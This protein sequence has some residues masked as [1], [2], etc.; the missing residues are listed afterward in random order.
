MPRCLRSTLAVTI[1]LVAFASSLTAQASSTLPRGYDQKEGESYHWSGW[2]ATSSYVPARTLYLYDAAAFPW[3]S[4]ART[5][6]GLRVR[7]DT[8]PHNVG[9]AAHRKTMRVYLST[10]GC[11]TVRRPVHEFASAHGNNLTLVFGSTAAPK[12]V[13]FRATA[14]L[15]SPAPFDVDFKLDRP[16][17][18]PANSPR[19]N[20]EFRAYTSNAGF[21]TLWW[22]DAYSS[23]ARLGTGSFS[24]SGAQ[25]CVSGSDTLNAWTWPGG[26]LHFMCIS[27]R[28]NAP[29]AL[30]LGSRLAPSLRIANTSCYLHV[31][32]VLVLTGVGDSVSGR[33][34][35]WLG[36]LPQNNQLVGAKLAYQFAVVARGLP[37]QG[38][39]GTTRGAEMTIG[40]G[41]GPTLA[42]AVYSYGRAASQPDRVRFGGFLTS[43]A[44]VLE[45]R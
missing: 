35:F 26:G 44:P 6:N 40:T 43:R 20:V 39:I 1:P 34:D 4:A 17:V 2:G 5:I 45:I 27:N 18:V 33:A 19:L 36:C 14:V 21:N 30:L 37:I 9:F 38:L 32:P 29:V 22:V 8:F 28:P 31:T 23:G 10:G 16:F 11:G 24:E 3:G 15:P 12:L 42:S 7:R 25:N 13:D 41:W